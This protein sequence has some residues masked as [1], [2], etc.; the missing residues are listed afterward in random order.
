[1]TGRCRLVALH[2]FLGRPSDWDQLVQWFPD[3]SLVA[4]DLWSVLSEPGVDDW[5]SMSH[6]LDLALADAIGRGGA[7]PA[8]VIAYSFGARLALSSAML[9]LP[10]SP[11][12]GCC[13]VSCNPGLGQG[14]AAARAARRASDEAWARRILDW[15]E[16]D[17]WR[18][19]DKQPVFD[20][21]RRPAPRH[22][23]PAPRVV[24]A[25]ALRRF[26]LAEQ[27]DARPRLRAW[28]SPVLWITGALD[29]RF[30]ALARDLSPDV[31]SAT[32]VTCEAA[33][34]R[35]PWDNPAAFA[36]AVRAWRARV[37]E[38]SR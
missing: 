10:G 11:A 4:L 32:F 22:D 19:W 27:P 36:R 17:V 20:G 24:L 12:R 29:A 3:S 7:G 8:F 16:D 15:P 37:M 33:G 9:A 2:G 25:G 31:A 6:G 23:L 5:P 14:D 34:H 30:S 26:S 28:P 35:V 18:A 38:S 1:M 13:F 21:S